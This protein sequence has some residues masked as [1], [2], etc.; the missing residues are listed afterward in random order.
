MS[1]CTIVF[2]A[3]NALVSGV[4]AGDQIQL[5]LDLLTFD[6]SRTV[7]KKTNTTMSGRAT[8]TKF[9]GEEKYFLTAKDSGL[10]TFED[11][12]TTALTTE[13]MEMFLQ[14]VDNSEIFTVTDLDN[15][16]VAFDAKLSGDPSRSRVTSAIL[17]QFE[18]SFTVRKT[19]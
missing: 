16:N 1:N 18:Y 11:T 8:S 12:S 5:D 2:E 17:D 9:Y 15:G 6:Y 19:L 13:Y 3:K 4:T 14:S 10:V 7:N